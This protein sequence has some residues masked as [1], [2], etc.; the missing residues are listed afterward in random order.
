MFAGRVAHTPFEEERKHGQV[1]E[2][3]GDHEFD[4]ADGVVAQV[5]PVG[6]KHAEDHREGECGR[7]DA[8]GVVAGGTRPAVE[9]DA[10]A[11]GR[12]EEGCVA[13]VVVQR[14]HHQDRVADT[15]SAAL[16]Q[17]LLAAVQPVG[18]VPGEVDLAVGAG[19]PVQQY[20]A[21]QHRRHNL[22]RFTFQREK[23]TFLRPTGKSAHDPCRC[24]HANQRVQHLGEHG[25]CDNWT[26]NVHANRTVAVGEEKD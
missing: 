5:E 26:V 21:V 13:G 19:R 2:A 16:R 8:T 17:R 12:V 14:R 24:V 6:A 4:H 10:S 1:A 22:V 25:R 9:A 15:Q 11:G 3:G 20:V 23:A 7:P 18:T